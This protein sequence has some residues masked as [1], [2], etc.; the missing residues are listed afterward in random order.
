MNLSSNQENLVSGAYTLVEL[1]TIPADYTD[2]IENIGTHR[3]TPGQPGFYAIVGQV[4]F[5]GVVADTSY[6][7]I[8]E[9]NG[10]YVC[11]H[12]VDASQVGAISVPAVLPNIKIGL[13]DYIELFA[14]SMAGVDTVDIDS[15]P[16][17]TFLSVQ[18]VR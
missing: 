5:M 8:I 6:I 13:T 11:N 7:T 18:R 1:D 9:V 4:H 14:K 16:Y 12:I 2:G 15:T 17:R 10:S 3:I